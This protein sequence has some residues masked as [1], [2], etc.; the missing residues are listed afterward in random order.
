[1]LSRREFLRIV[2]LLGASEL[3]HDVLPALELMV[4][5]DSGNQ[6]PTNAEP[7]QIQTLRQGSESVTGYVQSTLDA[8]DQALATLAR[9]PA[10]LSLGL[11][12]DY[13]SSNTTNSVAFGGV[14]SIDLENGRFA[15]GL[16]LTT[17]TSATI[18]TNPLPDAA[19]GAGA[20]IGTGQLRAGFYGSSNVASA[21]TI[22]GTGEGASMSVVENDEYSAVSANVFIDPGLPSATTSTSSE[23]A[24]YT[25][26]EGTVVEVD[27]SSWVSEVQNA[28]WDASQD[29]MDPIPAPAW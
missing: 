29:P 25:Y 16:F 4:S 22:L 6:A 10:I 3:V 8:L 19:L 17:T 23:P 27:L 7:K 2:E 15:A 1:M 14:L 18:S 5:L 24:S 9:Q 20:S 28:L 26:G 12:A 21:G 11:E 13:S